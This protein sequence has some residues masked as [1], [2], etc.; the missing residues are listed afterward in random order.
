MP[1]IALG[2]LQKG[3]RVRD[4]QFTGQCREAWIGCPHVEFSDECGRQNV[5]VDPPNTSTIESSRSHK[6]HNFL[7][8]DGDSL[9]HLQVGIDEMLS[10]TAYVSDKQLAKNHLVADY[11]VAAKKLIK[12]T[13][14][15]FSTSEETDPDRRVD[16]DHHAA[17]LLLG[18]SL[19]RGT[20]RADGAV[21]RSER[22]LS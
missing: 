14:K 8:R 10:P 22:S 1:I 12:A 19:W 21:P 4:P 15:G 11:L 16:Q 9:M 18:C 3:R 13:G 17:L 20:S 5:Y 7:M 2:G 6:L